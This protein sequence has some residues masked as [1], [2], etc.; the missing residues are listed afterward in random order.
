MDTIQIFACDHRKNVQWDLPFIRLG[1]E[2][3]GAVLT[4]ANDQEIQP[5]AIKLSEGAQIWWVWKHLAE[6]GNPSYVGFCHYRRFFGAADRLIQDFPSGCLDLSRIFNPADQLHMIL[7]TKVDG[8]VPVCFNPLP[9]NN[10]VQYSTVAQQTKLISDHD[11]LGFTSKVI[12]KAFDLLVEC[13]PQ[14]LKDKVQAAYSDSDIFVCNIFTLKTSLFNEY[15]QTVFAAVKKLAEFA[16][17][18][19]TSKFHKRW[20]GYI[21]ERYTSSMLKAF[22]ADG[23]K[24]GIVPL[25]TIDGW[26]HEVFERHVGD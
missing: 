19:D 15:C 22:Q 13:A 11:G 23:A 26:K 14:R 17:D 20:M 5:F 6:L 25:L 10:Q 12:D 21:L 18:I 3:S 1:T 24:L 4:I 16:E 7:Q 9:K 8:I 2:D